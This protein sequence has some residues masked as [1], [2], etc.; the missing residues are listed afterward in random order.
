MSKRRAAAGTTAN[1]RAQRPRYYQHYQPDLPEIPGVPPD[2]TP[3]LVEALKSTTKFFS[4][5][6][7]PFSLEPPNEDHSTSSQQSLS[8]VDSIL[9]RMECSAEEKARTKRL[10]RMQSDCQSWLDA[11][12]RRAPESHRGSSV[13]LACFRYLWGLGQEHGR[14]AVR[15]ASLNLCGTLLLKSCGCRMHVS[16]DDTL[17]KWVTCVVDAKDVKASLEIQVSCWQAEAL[18]W[19]TH[20]S[21]MYGEMYPK[22][23]V[24]QQFLQQRA[25]IDAVMTQGNSGANMVD[26]RRIRDIA[27]KYADAELEKVDKLI[28]RGHDLLDLLVPRVGVA[29]RGT[30]EAAKPKANGTDDDGSEADED[31]DIVWED[32]DEE[33]D[34]TAGK[35]HVDAVEKTLAAMASSGGLQGGHIE[36][37]L[38][39][40]EDD[41]ESFTMDGNTSRRLQK[42]V[43]LIETRHLKRLS[44]WVDGLVKADG[45]VLREKSL[46]IMSSEESRKRAELLQKLLNRKQTLANILASAAKLGVAVEPNTNDT[47]DELR[48]IATSTFR[49]PQRQIAVLATAARRRTDGRVSRKR[50]TKLQIKCRK[51]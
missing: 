33:F 27:T 15:R 51:S 9:N 8:V 50:S 6:D 2:L 20:L 40:K 23:Y 16:S 39:S 3:K 30:V 19:F 21:D 38:E 32:G 47:P 13:P 25:S 11:V 24:A 1:G 41:E 18:E 48:H 29:V 10:E 43:Q 4:K 46:I 49:P 26:L 45:L 42:T 5:S 35:Q 36:I 12:K 34:D 17:L 22:F 7:K 31:D 44:S 37:N 14:V 28:Q